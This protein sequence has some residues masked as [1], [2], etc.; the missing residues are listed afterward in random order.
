MKPYLISL[1]MGAVAGVIYYALQVQSPAPPVI[2]LLGLLG[3]LIGEQLVP[4]IRRKLAGEPITA[5]W[6]HRECIPKI[7]GAPPPEDKQ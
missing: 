2:A 6:F 5:A 3:M 1:L 4:I 7:T